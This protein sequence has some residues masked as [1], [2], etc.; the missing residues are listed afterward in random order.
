MVVVVVVIGGGVVVFRRVSRISMTKRLKVPNLTGVVVGAV[1][2]FA[3]RVS[4]KIKA[5]PK[6]SDITVVVVVVVI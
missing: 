2:V 1:V 6:T 4:R 3:H 5:A